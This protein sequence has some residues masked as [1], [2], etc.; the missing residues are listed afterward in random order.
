MV[1]KKKTKRVKKGLGLVRKIRWLQST[2]RDA[3]LVISGLT[4]EGKSTLAIWIAKNLDSGFGFDRNLAYSHAEVEEKI[5][6]LPRRSVIVI[7]EAIN[8]LYRRDFMRGEQKSLIK[9]LNVCRFRNLCLVFNIPNLFDLDSAI[10]NSRIRY[11]VWVRKRGEAFLFRIKRTPF[12]SDPWN[13]SKNEKLFKDNKLQNSPNLVCKVRFPKLSRQDFEEYLGVQKKKKVN[14]E[15]E[16][17]KEDEMIV[18]THRKGYESGYKEGYLDVCLDFEKVGIIRYGD[19]KRFCK[20]TNKS[21]GQFI[22]QLSRWRK[23]KVTVT[24]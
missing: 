22:K 12:S 11:W 5:K 10:L 20:A 15:G 3:V 24:I 21:Y 1:L 18:S 6:S 8:V 19:W 16:Q 23:E 4:G 2:D 9:L 13:K 7:D 14:T 17:N